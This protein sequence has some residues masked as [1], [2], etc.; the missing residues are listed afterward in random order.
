M[1][2]ATKGRWIGAGA[3]LLVTAAWLTTCLSEACQTCLPALALFGGLLIGL[4]YGIVAG[5]FVGR[6]AGRAR[7]RRG[8][9][10]V[11][12][13]AWA[14]A[15]DVVVCTLLSPAV[16]DESFVFRPDVDALAAT[17]VVLSL[18]IVIPGA[19]L[20]E[21]TTRPH[22]VVPRAAIR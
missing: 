20:L 8:L 9:V 12:S 13:L 7:E 4:P 15:V 3:A 6:F 11:L 14:L 10:I 5:S 17:L 22:D 2:P 21:R 1:T 16:A 18:A 19:V